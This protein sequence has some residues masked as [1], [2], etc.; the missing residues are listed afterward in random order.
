[1]INQNQA[2]FSL[3]ETTFG[4]NGVT[5]F[6]LP[7]LRGRVPLHTS[8]AYPRGRAGGA[9]RYRL[10]PAH[11]PAHTHTQRQ[12][13]D[14]TTGNPNATASPT[15]ALLAGGP[16]LLYGPPTNLVALEPDTVSAVGGN[17]P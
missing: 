14:A 4:G 2:L 5:T 1:P 12:A 10:T 16:S 17:Q 6:A 3:L 13:T 9:E 11:M 8:D 15:D 7:D